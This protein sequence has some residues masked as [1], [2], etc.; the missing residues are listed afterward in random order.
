MGAFFSRIVLTLPF[1]F[2]LEKKYTICGGLVT[3]MKK[4]IKAHA[5]EYN[6]PDRG[7]VTKFLYRHSIS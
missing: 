2:F 7:S 3:S 1:P 4:T 6:I 5:S